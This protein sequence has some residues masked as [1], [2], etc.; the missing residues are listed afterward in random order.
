MSETKK[1]DFLKCSKVTVRTAK[2]NRHN[3]HANECIISEALHM[4]RMQCASSVVALHTHTHTYTHT[5]THT[6]TH[7]HTHRHTHKHG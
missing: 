5:H 7:T 3:M 4:H 6:Y 2:K 1:K